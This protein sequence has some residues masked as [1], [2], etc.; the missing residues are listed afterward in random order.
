VQGERGGCSGSR[1]D[2]DDDPIG[3]AGTEIP[4]SARSSVARLFPSLDAV[5]ADV[6]SAASCGILLTAASPW[7]LSTFAAGQ[8]RAK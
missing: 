2:A 6:A 7:M 1:E 8:A 3:R 5:L 4:V